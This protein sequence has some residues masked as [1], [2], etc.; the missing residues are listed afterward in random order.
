MEG[1]LERSRKQLMQRGFV[2]KDN[3]DADPDSEFNQEEFR[4][5]V[6]MCEFCLTFPRQRTI[7]LC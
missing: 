7:P 5:L 3:F 1:D 2:D 4:K 6:P